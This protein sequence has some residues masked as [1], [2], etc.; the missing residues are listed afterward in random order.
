MTENDP[1]LLWRATRQATHDGNRHVMMQADRSF[2]T[3]TKRKKDMIHSTISYSV[4][5]VRTLSTLVH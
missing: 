5:L 2:Q 4:F 3:A 1:S